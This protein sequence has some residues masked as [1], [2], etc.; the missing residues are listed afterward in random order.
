MS[1][2]DPKRTLLLRYSPYCGVLIA[3]SA[4]ANIILR[5]LITAPR[6]H[7]HLTAAPQATPRMLIIVLILAWLL[8]FGL[9]VASR[10]TGRKVSPTGPTVRKLDGEV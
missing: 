3:S 5:I 10:S 7:A 1:A 4:A 6:S 2:S 9:A 8:V